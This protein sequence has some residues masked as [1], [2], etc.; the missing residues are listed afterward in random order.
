M[1][2]LFFILVFVV[3]VLIHELGHF[4]AMKAAKVDVKEFGIGLPPRAFRFWRGKSHIIINGQRLE[5]P[6]NLDLTIDKRNGLNKQVNAT[7]DSVNGALVLRTIEL[8][9]T[10]E[11]TSPAAGEE[12]RNKNSGG[13][14]LVEYGRKPE[15]APPAR[16]AIELNGIASEI[17]IG[18]EFTLNW[19]PFGGF[20]LPSGEND[21]AVPGGLAAASPWK[22]LGVLFAGPAMNL[23]AG[24]LIYTLL[25]FQT[26]IPDVNKVVLIE[27][28]PGSPAAQ[29]GFQAGDLLLSANETPINS[30]DDIRNI[31][32]ANIDQPVVIVYAR[33]GEQIT[34]TVVPSSQRTAEEGATGVLLGN[35]VQQA[36]ILT[37]AALGLRVTGLYIH[38]ILT[39]PA[40]IIQGTIPSDQARFIGLK[41]MYDFMSQAVTKDQQ[42]RQAPQQPAGTTAEQPTYYTMLL[43]ATLTISLGIFNLLPFPALDGGRIIFLLPELIFRRRVPPNIEA[44]VHA[45]G[46][47]LLLV[48]MLYINLM[49]FINPIAVTLP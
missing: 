29:A 44:T 12:N 38:E 24:V 30:T 19:L 8:V 49:D 34:A 45:V 26:G 2:L 16:G 22:R 14:P 5:I 21:P 15:K 1:T 4:S 7:A 9:K 35:P 32:Y 3:L 39:L 27:V 28:S 47:M 18:T 36:N 41:G 23:L 13:P 40:R 43:I 33:N 10:E 11:I 46:I 42:T 37:A 6:R 20:V 48:L 17:N 31:I 25:F